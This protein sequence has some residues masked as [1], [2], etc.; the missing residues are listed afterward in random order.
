MKK[1]IRTSQD[2]ALAIQAI[3]E[4]S[5]D[6]PQLFTLQDA[7]DDRTGCQNR[8]YWMWMAEIARHVESSTGHLADV[9][10]ISE[11]MK[12]TLYPQIECDKQIIFPY[13][14]KKQGKYEERVRYL[15]TSK[16]GVKIMAVYM[17]GLDMYCA[18]R[19]N[20][21]LS[22]PDDLWHEAIG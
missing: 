9:E 6:H 7:S 8:L 20:L 4:M 10:T 12:E 22:H 21:Q 5:L 19:L 3:N 13:K 18:A 16:L 11:Q 14:I 2:K 15:S 1:I 17:A